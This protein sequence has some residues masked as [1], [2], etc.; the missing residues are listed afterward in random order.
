ME[1]TQDYYLIKLKAA[2]TDKQRVNPQYS[3]RAFANYLGVHPSVLSPILNGKRKLPQKYIES[4]TDRLGLSPKEKALFVLSL[5]KKKASLDKIK[6]PD[7]G[8]EKFVIDESYHH[9]IAEWEHYA[10]LCLLQT[11]DFQSDLQ[12]I[13]QRL[14]VTSSRLELVIHN[15][16]TAQIIKKN[17]DGDFERITGPL[18]TTEDIKSAAIRKS[19]KESLELASSKLDQIELNLRDFSSLRFPANPEKI[20]SAKQIIREFQEKLEVLMRDEDANQV[21]QCSVQL[22]PLTQMNEEKYNEV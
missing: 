15:L 3:L 14:G 8:Q 16:M 17:E 5:Y 18:R 7:L 21:Y 9:I 19:H 1:N 11:S 13:A 20:S 10:F 22:F 2:F 4:V 6:L 12:W